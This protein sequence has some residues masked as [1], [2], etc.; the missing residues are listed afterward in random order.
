MIPG[1]FLIPYWVKF[2]IQ[3]YDFAGIT[4]SKVGYGVTAFDKYDAFDI[5]KREA[6][7]NKQLPTV[8]EIIENVSFDYLDAGH[9]VPNMGVIVER[10][11]WFPNI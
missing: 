3:N 8:I 5:L 11:V 7:K 1:K 9:V 6:F 10:G 2:D 4:L